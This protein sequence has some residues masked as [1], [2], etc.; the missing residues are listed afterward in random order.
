VSCHVLRDLTGAVKRSSTCV[1]LTLNRIMLVSQKASLLVYFLLTTTVSVAFVVTNTN[2]KHKGESTTILEPH[3]RLRKYVSSYDT[4]TRTSRLFAASDKDSDEE[5]QE[6][7]FDLEAA[8]KQ[9]ESMLVHDDDDD[10]L[11]RTLSSSQDGLLEY[12]LSSSEEE[13]IELPPPPPLSTIERDRKVAEIQILKGLANGD[14]ASQQLWALWYSERGGTAKAQLEKADGLMSNPDTWKECETLLKGLV[15]DFGVYFV[16]PLNRLATLY[17]LQ[18]KFEKGYILCLIILKIKPWHFGALSGIVQVCI[19]RGDRNGARYWAEK[20]LPGMVP[21]TSSPPFPEEGPV[22]PRRQEWVD[23]Q[24]AKA[25]KLMTK[26][27]RDTKK[28]FGELDSYHQDRE[29][30]DTMNPTFLEDEDGSAWQ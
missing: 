2:V 28:S 16:E 17:F 30:S 6:S 25:E 4:I 8:R 12:L 13:S 21:G 5:S 1:T 20:R 22:N 14:D 23:E 26:A 9:L 29:E 24:V 18:S 11:K 19:G 3:Q 10:K 27:E 15:D 7:Q